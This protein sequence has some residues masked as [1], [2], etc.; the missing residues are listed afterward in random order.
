MDQQ[1][2]LL[3]PQI[4]SVEEGL[5]PWN[6]AT[7]P[8]DPDG[9][10]HQQPQTAPDTLKADNVQQVGKAS[11]SSILESTSNAPSPSPSASIRDS[12]SMHSLPVLQVTEP[13][14]S[15]SLP[16]GPDIPS[17]SDDDS[18]TPVQ[19][20]VVS[21]ASAPPPSRRGNPRY[22]STIDV[23]RFCLMLLPLFSLSMISILHRVDPP[24]VS[25]VFF[26]SSSI[27]VTMHPPLLVLQHS[28]NKQI[29]RKVP[30]LPHERLPPCQRSDLPPHHHPYHLLP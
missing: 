1:S 12:A 16:Q 18:M 23:R 6:D 11:H 10:R 14:H 21:A 2:L 15:P 28:K 4:P 19:T 30:L 7:G 13:Q 22:R 27:D 25:L 26:P 9:P 29:L 3:T 17:Q 8:F 20:S 24:A 5:A